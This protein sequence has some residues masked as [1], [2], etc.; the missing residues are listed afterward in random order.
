METT[1]FLLFCFPQKLK[2]FLKIF[3]IHFSKNM[4]L[5]NLGGFC[6]TSF[7]KIGL[8]GVPL[9]LH[10]R[11]A[12]NA[13][14]PYYPCRSFQRVLQRKTRRR[15]KIRKQLQKPY[16]VALSLPQNV[17]QQAD[18]TEFASRTRRRHKIRKQLQKRYRV[19]PYSSFT[20]I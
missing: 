17:G 8:F 7:R 1:I 5:Q 3:I 14:R 16:R 13:S 12:A 20:P 10:W 9:S 19:A 2:K 6:F 18:L 15:H 11:Q 4:H